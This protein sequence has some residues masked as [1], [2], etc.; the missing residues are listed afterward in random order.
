[1]LLS[2]L[3]LAWTAV[4]AITDLRS[5]QI[6]NWNT[7]SGMLVALGVRF[8]T[9]DTQSLLDGLIGLGVCGGIMLLGFVLFNVGGGDVKLLAMLG[10]FLG[11]EQG[12]EVMLWTFTFGCISAI[13][14]LIW[15]TGAVRMV[16]GVLHHLRLMWTGRGWVPL[17]AAEREPLQATLFLAPS[18][19]L[20]LVLVTAPVWM[21]AFE[22]PAGGR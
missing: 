12:I 21:A 19:L 5:H 18:A 15:H 6:L 16:R 11:L 1:M 17:Q 22:N 13:A 10:A 7:Y 20:A 3:S 4:A 14:M 9:G 2:G 8:L